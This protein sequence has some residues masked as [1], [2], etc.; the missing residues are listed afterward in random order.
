MA[1]HWKRQETDDN[2]HELYIH[3]HIYMYVHVITGSHLAIKI[4]EIKEQ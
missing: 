2:P 1:L 4:F 3:T